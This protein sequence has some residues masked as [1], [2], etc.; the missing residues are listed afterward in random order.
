MKVVSLVKTFSKYQN[1]DQFV[2]I[3]KDR[4]V[5]QIKYARVQDTGIY[6]CE[7]SD[8]IKL[9]LDFWIFKKKQGFKMAVFNQ[10]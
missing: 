10:F 9:K 3:A 8:K 7:V 6:K 2:F 4:W 1:T 5:L